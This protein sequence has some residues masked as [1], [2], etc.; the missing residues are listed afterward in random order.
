MDNS[1]DTQP[2]E[3]K[4]VESNDQQLI[5][6][7]SAVK[8]GWASRFKPNKSKRIIL[9]ILLAMLCVAVTG[10]WMSQRTNQRIL[11]DGPLGSKSTYISQSDLQKYLKEQMRTP[12][13][14]ELLTFDKNKVNSLVPSAK[15]A[16]S[17]K[18]K[19]YTEP[20]TDRINNSS[21]NLCYYT[22][23]DQGF[24][25]TGYTKSCYVRYTAFYALKG[26]IYNEAITQFE[27]KYYSDQNGSHAISY[28]EG[29]CTKSTIG[30][31]GLQFS[32]DFYF[33][34]AGTSFSDINQYFSAY[35][36]EP[37]G[38]NMTYQ[39]RGP[40]DEAGVDGYLN[41]NYALMDKNLYDITMAITT[42]NQKSKVGFVM[43]G[44]TNQYYRETM[45]WPT[46]N[47]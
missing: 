47:H 44:A 16:L 28:N 13:H 10:F 4:R 26:P 22:G 36:G 5:I 27:G 41:I 11:L 9:Y 18:M 46:K 2:V 25:T 23:I 45:D 3:K 35:P 24:I 32:A 39:T 8:K 31:A 15:S 30:S 19:D 34:P 12:T 43:I 20:Y 6:D 29:P 40:L 14:D 21:V 38:A 1:Y 7:D 17:D 42:A 37:I 33:C